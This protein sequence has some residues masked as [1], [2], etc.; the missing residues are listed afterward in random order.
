M[1][2]IYL[3]RYG[4]MNATEQYHKDTNSK[5]SITHQK[6]IYQICVAKYLYA[7]TCSL[8]LYVMR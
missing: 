7:Q 5:F 8:F 2:G 4:C 1:K 6:Y 3:N